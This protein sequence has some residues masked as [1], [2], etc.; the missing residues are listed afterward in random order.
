MVQGEVTA[1]PGV[2]EGGTIYIQDAGMGMKVYLS[3]G[4]YP[5]LEDGD[6]VQVEGKLSDYHGEREVTVSTAS[7]V[8][9]L[10]SGTP[11]GPVPVATGELGEVYEGLL[12]EVVGRVTGWDWDT[13]YL[14]DGSGEVKVYFGRSEL[15]EKPWVEKG[16]LYLVVG[17]ASQYASA[18]PYEGGYRLLPRYEGDVIAAPFELPVTGGGLRC[19]A[20]QV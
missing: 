15:V 11:L 6:W 16:E 4:T 8:Q 1:P 10:R 17:L 3:E 12:V 20:R 2:L 13:I 5:P 19:H 14:D 7:R 18:R 9:R